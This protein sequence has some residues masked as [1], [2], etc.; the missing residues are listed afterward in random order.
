MLIII[1]KLIRKVELK[2]GFFLFFLKNKI[3][4][5]W[6]FFYDNVVSVNLDEIKRLLFEEINLNYNFYLLLFW[7]CVWIW[8]MIFKCYK[9]EV[10]GCFKNNKIYVYLILLE[11]VN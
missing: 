8:F 10:I 9:K 6:R 2:D 7:I 1:L 11:F 5:K 3:N 4:W